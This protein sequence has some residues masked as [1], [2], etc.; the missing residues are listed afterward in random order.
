MLNQLPTSVGEN[1]ICRCKCHCESWNF[2]GSYPE[3]DLEGLWEN[4]VEATGSLPAFVNISLTLNGKK[5]KMFLSQCSVL[6][7]SI[8]IC[9]NRFLQ[10]SGVILS[11]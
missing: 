2:Q 8:M 6:C 7:H 11:M 9:L 3:Y 5:L 4:D 1:S 10:H